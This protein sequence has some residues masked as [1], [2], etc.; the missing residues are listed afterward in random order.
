MQLDETIR[1]IELDE[2]L[3]RTG[4]IE[5]MAGAVSGYLKTQ[6]PTFSLRSAIRI[7]CPQVE[8]QPLDNKAAY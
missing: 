1:T 4:Q 8:L 5:A 2:A 7:A 6:E 3:D